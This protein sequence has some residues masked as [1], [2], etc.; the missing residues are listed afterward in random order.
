MGLET[1]AVVQE[2]P[3]MAGRCRRR[4]AGFGALLGAG[5]LLGGCATP[6]QTAALRETPPADLPVRA[7]IRSAPFFPQERHQCGPA[8]LATVLTHHGRPVTPAELVPRVYL[9]AREGSVPVEMVA[10]ARQAGMLAYPL[11]PSLADALREVAA[12]HPL[13]VLQN[14]GLDWAPRWHYAVLI[15][16]DLETAEAILRS[17]TV[18]R[19]VTPLATFERTWA[20]AGHRAWVILPPG[21]MP[22]TAR[23]VPYLEAAADLESRGQRQAAYAAWRAAVQRWPKAARAWLTWGNA[24]YAQ[25][26]VQ[27]AVTAF[28]R[29]TRLQPALASAWNNLAYALLGDGC[30]EQA[31]RAIECALQ[32]APADPNLLDSQREIGARAQGRDRR[33]CP[34]LRCPPHSPAEPPHEP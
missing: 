26:D 9:P 5:L 18:R 30:P 19:W 4:R 34:R 12:G 11:A 1:G 10:A 15:G 23:L 14:L 28:R 6:P 2:S 17:G 16:Y 27:G 8:A 20:R 31:V 25:G 21:Q 29:A 24:L 22:A 32:R 3:I 13:L 7:E 33:H